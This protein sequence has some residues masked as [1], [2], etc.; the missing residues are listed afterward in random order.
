MTNTTRTNRT[1][2]GAGRG[3]ER[4]SA[5]IIL[6]VA[7]MVASTL[8]LSLLAV[9]MGRRGATEGRRAMESALLVAEAGLAR[10]LAEA[11]LAANRSNPL[12]PLRTL[13]TSYADTCVIDAADSPRDDCYDADENKIGEYEISFVRGDE[14][15]VDNN[16]NTI[17]D[18]IPPVGAT[19]A[20]LAAAAADAVAEAFYVSINSLGY[21]GAASATNRFK[22]RLRGQFQKVVSQFN[23]K[24]AVFIDDPNPHVDLEASNA[25]LVSG[26][27][28]D[29]TGAN[30]DEVI[31]ANDLPALA[32]S[33]AF[34]GTDTAEIDSYA[35]GKKPQ[36]EGS[37]PYENNVL[38]DEGEPMNYDMDEIVE[39]ARDAVDPAN[40]FTATGVDVGGPAGEP[41]SDWQ[42]T[43]HDAGGPGNVVKFAG[44]SPHGAG[45]WIIDG[46]AEFA[47]NFNFSG[48]IIVT[49]SVNYTGGGNRTFLGAIISGESAVLA[50]DN[51]DVGGNASIKFSSAAVTAAAN[52]AARYSMVGWQKLSAQ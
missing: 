10:G 24:S 42:V 3:G 16:G 38:N 2:Q 6:V 19:P 37:S 26:L 32:S 5:M 11:N 50:A 21:H 36:I 46:D 28:H 33:G 39:W 15:T 4:G 17:T 51:I 35:G 20:Q 43:M 1:L 14:D 22:V 44:G 13:D 45:V 41:P 49:G 12:W 48:I 8:A 47:G 52:A 40:Y 7:I 25:W 29:L 31:D 30:T 34:D 18:G 23:V 9:A 27:D